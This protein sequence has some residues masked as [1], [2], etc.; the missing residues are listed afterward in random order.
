MVVYETF[1]GIEPNKD[2]FWRLFEVKSLW[3]H[4]SSGGA[5]ALVGGMNI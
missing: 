3:V 1:L 4:G 2:L 5:L